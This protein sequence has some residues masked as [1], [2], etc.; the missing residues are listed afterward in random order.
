MRARDVHMGIEWEVQLVLPKYP[1]KAVHVTTAVWGALGV[2][3]Y[4]EHIVLCI[5]MKKKAY[6]DMQNLEFRTKKTRLPTLRAEI[7]RVEELE[8]APLILDLARELDTAIGVFLPMVVGETAPSKHVSISLH[9]LF[10]SNPFS[11]RI[12]LKASR[13][14]W[15]KRVHI[16][17][18]YNFT[19]YRELIEIILENKEE[20]KAFVA[21]WLSRWADKNPMEEPLFVGYTQTGDFWVSMEGLI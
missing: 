17:V 10:G 5:P 20:G 14:G 6:I 15:R 9:D 11:T 3:E 2:D 7:K 19:A 16:T 18:P 4:E 8:L 13:T 21:E 1:K 12:T